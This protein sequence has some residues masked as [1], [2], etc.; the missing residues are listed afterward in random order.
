MVCI[1]AAPR[2]EPVRHASVGGGNGDGGGELGLGLGGGEAAAAAATATASM[3]MSPP[4]GHGGSPGSSGVPGAATPV[5]EERFDLALGLLALEVE[6]DDESQ[7]ASQA[8]PSSN[9]IND[10]ATSFGLALAL[11][12]RQ[13]FL[14]MLPSASSAWLRRVARFGMSC[15]API[16]IPPGSSKPTWI[17]S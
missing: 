1:E 9:G 5:F 16:T 2:S 12:E 17:S 4:G 15:K 11:V 13:C 6:L 7:S 3:P 10:G 8:G 14:R